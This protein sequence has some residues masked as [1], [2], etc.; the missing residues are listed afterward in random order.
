ML[1]DALCKA[2]R[3]DGYLPPNSPCIEAATASGGADVDG[4]SDEEFLE[5][6]RL[7]SPAMLRRTFLLAW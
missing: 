2:N 4:Y 3:M 1:H 5:L 6:H 7:I